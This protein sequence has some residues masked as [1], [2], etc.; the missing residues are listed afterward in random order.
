MTELT[1]EVF[2]ESGFAKK[3]QGSLL[4]SLTNPRCYSYRL[5]DEPPVLHINLT[6]LLSCRRY[7]GKCML[8]GTI[9]GIERVEIDDAPRCSPFL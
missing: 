9:V 4:S 3:P 8:D 7:H 2:E 5:D 1:P 6:A